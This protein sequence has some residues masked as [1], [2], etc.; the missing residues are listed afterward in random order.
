MRYSIVS[1]H[2]QFRAPFHQ[3]WFFPI[4]KTRHFWRPN[5]IAV[6]GTGTI[7]G[8][9]KASDTVPSILWGWFFTSIQDISSYVCRVCCWILQEDHVQV[10]IFLCQQLP[11]LRC[12]VL[13]SLATYL[14]W[15]PGH[16][17]F[18]LYLVSNIILD[19]SIFPCSY[20]Q[21]LQNIFWHSVSRCLTL[22]IV[23]FLENCTI[24]QYGIPLS[25][26]PW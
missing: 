15:Y 1:Y 8:I 19:P 22:R 24:Y 2:H 12:S 13:W 14:A 5:E 17:L 11:L 20:F 9:L 18:H 10:S 7:P 21:L 6:I 25:L 26:Y 4:T 3:W 23:I 16:P